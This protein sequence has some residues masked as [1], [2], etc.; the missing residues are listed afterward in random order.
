MPRLAVYYAMRGEGSIAA[1][2]FRACPGD[3]QWAQGLCM[4]HGHRGRNPSR[5]RGQRR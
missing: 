4:S 2:F 3:G 1:E 5:E